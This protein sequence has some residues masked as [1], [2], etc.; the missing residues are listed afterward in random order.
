M[1]QKKAQRLFRNNFE[2]YKHWF[3]L[4]DWKIDLHFHTWLGVGESG[5]LAVARVENCSWEYQSASIQ[6]DL[7]KLADMKASKI[8]EV[9]IHELLHIVVNEMR[10]G[11]IKHEERVVTHLTNCVLWLKRPK[12]EVMK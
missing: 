1:K 5:N 9:V 8:G 12:D 11:S 6:V 2:H 4:S 3:G 7:S 10:E